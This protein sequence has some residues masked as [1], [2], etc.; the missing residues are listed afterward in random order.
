MKVRLVLISLCISSLSASAAGP[1][2]SGWSITV[3]GGPAFPVM[4][5]FSGSAA[6]QSTTTTDPDGNEVVTG[7]SANILGLDWS[8]A[9]DD[10]L[11]LAIEIDFWEGPTRSLY[12]GL[13]RTMASGKNAT[14]GSFNGSNV[15]AT[16][17][18]YSDT[19]IYAGFR[20]GLG[21]SGWIK[22][23][24]SVQ[25][26]ATIID[27]IDADVTNIPNV[28]SIAF[29]Q[30]STVFSG[31]VFIS[32]ILTPLDFLEVGIESGF[33]YQTAPKGDNSQI[34]LLGLQGIN[35]EGDLGLV[36]VRILA[37]IKF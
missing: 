22:S 13:S 17:S 8:D 14:L 12:L 4:G 29:Y 23:L 2:I 6:E 32:V 35:S 34:D 3:K 26:G 30:R 9:Y 1:D 5:D 20:W 19:G 7:N 15:T 37:T 33:R 27:S 18:D 28:T 21:N 16:F 10:F 11:D 31:G 25:A 24:I 36:P